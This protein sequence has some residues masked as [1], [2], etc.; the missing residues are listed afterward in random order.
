MVFTS[1]LFRNC[2]VEVNYLLFEI[3]ELTVVSS[4]SVK[5]KHACLITAAPNLVS[6]IF[7]VFA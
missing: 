7:C 4:D 1:S 3:V 6:P 2:F 5:L